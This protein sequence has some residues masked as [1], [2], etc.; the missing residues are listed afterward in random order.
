[1]KSFV[2]KAINYLKARI[3]KIRYTQRCLQKYCPYCGLLHLL[4]WR[5]NSD[6]ILAFWTIS[7]RLRR[8]CTCSAHFISFIF[9]RSFLT[10]SSHRDLCL[11][12]GLH[13]NAFHLCILFTM[14]VSGILFL[15][16]NQLNL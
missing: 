10:S 7:L 12:A 1:M 9:F 11:P 13:V 15:C 16:P 3:C 5:Y 8:S 4:L 6:S 2:V 14:L